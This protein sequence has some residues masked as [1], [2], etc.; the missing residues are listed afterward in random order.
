MQL[1]QLTSPTDHTFVDVCVGEGEFTNM[2]IPLEPPPP[3]NTPESMGG[4]GGGGNVPLARYPLAPCSIVGHKQHP[5]GTPCDASI[6]HPGIL[7]ALGTE[8]IVYSYSL[9]VPGIRD[10]PT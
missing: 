2:N 9:T 3:P 10:N 1:L 5:F 8:P 4:G 7:M 6:C